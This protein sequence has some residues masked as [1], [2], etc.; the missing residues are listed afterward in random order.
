MNRLGI[1]GPAAVLSVLALLG[2]CS[3]G[4]SS[5]GGSSGT[6]GGTSG[7]SGTG[8]DGGAS[9]GTPGAPG[10]ALP[11]TTFLFERRVGP[12]KENLIA[13]DLATGAERVV[14]D[15]KSD[16]S[17]GWTIDGFSLSPDR[18]KIVIASQFGPTKADTDTL[19]ATQR[20]WTLDTEGKNFTRLTPVFKNSNIGTPGFR[21]DVR[22]PAFSADGAKVYYAYGEQTI[23]SSA[24]GTRTWSVAADGSALPELLDTPAACSVASAVSVDPATGKVLITQAVCA[25]ASD[26]AFVFFTA[27]GQ[28]AETVLP[29]GSLSPSLNQ[30]RWAP[31]GSVFLFGASEGSAAGL[32]AYLTD[33][34]AASKIIDA[35]PNRTIESGSVAPDGSAIVYCLRDGDAKDLHVLDLTKTPPVDSALTNDGASCNPSF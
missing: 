9:S 3:S 16:G 19:I 26:N 33:K 10:P 35:G 2:A 13:R 28:P 7:T 31:D 30:P 32:Y 24:G 18:T 25:Q 1:L 14:T 23:G 34:K 4:G 8:A 15:L 29:F 21:I 11:A 5:G 6:S 20:V 17:E 12:D 22:N 27:N